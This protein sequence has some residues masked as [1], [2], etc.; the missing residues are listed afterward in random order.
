MKYSSLA[1]CFTMS[2]SFERTA[3]A[4]DVLKR[5]PEA[6]R[7]VAKVARW[8]EITRRKKLPRHTLLQRF[9]RVSTFAT[10][11]KWNK[12]NVKAAKVAKWFG[13]PPEKRASEQKTGWVIPVSSR[14]AAKRLGDG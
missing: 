2:R 7:E 1:L 14:Q 8:I 5:P 13:R 4:L 9:F 10:W 12:R 3:C 6:G 11:H